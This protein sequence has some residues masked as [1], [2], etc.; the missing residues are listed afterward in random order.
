MFPPIL[1][2]AKN[3]CELGNNV[4]PTSKKLKFS[5]FFTLYVPTK[6]LEGGRKLELSENLT[7]VLLQ[8]FAW[9]KR[10]EF[11]RILSGNVI[12]TSIRAIT[13]LKICEK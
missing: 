5:F 12:L 10:P 13:L 8:C 3:T 4:N 2:L 11:L 7:I 6:T 9:S 1:I